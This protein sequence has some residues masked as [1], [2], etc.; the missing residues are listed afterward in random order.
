MVFLFLG[1]YGSLPD[2]AIWW[3]LRTGGGGVVIRAFR[4]YPIWCGSTGKSG[5]CSGTLQNTH[6]GRLTMAVASGNG[7]LMPRT[8]HCALR[9]LLMHQIDGRQPPEQGNI[10][11][12][13][14]EMVN[15]PQSAPLYRQLCI[16][17]TSECF[18]GHTPPPLNP[19]PNYIHL[20]GGASPV[21]HRAKMTVRGAILYVRH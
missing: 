9:L 13:R 4:R 20:L 11:W 12:V 15:A 18:E 21:A 19:P 16:T 1:A 7:P 6:N 14:V 3:C 10:I 8:R 5:S 2:A 17:T